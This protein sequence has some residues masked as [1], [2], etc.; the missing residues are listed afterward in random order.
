MQFECSHAAKTEIQ[1]AVGRER[2]NPLSDLRKSVRVICS[3]H[4]SGSSMMMRKTESGDRLTDDERESE[5]ESQSESIR[6]REKERED[7]SLPQ[8]Q[9]HGCHAH[10]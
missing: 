4:T 2:E 5:S 6:R 1:R 7:E 9:M 3:T 10:A 8:T